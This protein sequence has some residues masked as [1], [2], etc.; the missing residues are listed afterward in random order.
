MGR[1][2]GN[3]RDPEMPTQRTGRHHKLRSRLYCSIC[4]RRLSGTTIR[5]N[6]YTGAPTSPATPATTPPTP[7]TAPS[8]SAK[9]S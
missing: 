1:R 2:H 8:A 5:N 3:V 7:A 6:T 9:T 4:H